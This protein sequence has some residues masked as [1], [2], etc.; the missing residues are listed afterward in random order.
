MSDILRFSAIQGVHIFNPNSI[1]DVL[2]CLSQFDWS[3]Q[4]ISKDITISRTMQELSDITA[5]SRHPVYLKNLQIYVWLRII[6][7]CQP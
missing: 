2:G 1:Y 4:G 3:I 7:I 6:L 5:L